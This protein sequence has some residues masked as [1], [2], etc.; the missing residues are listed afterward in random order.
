MTV[1]PE[2]DPIANLDPVAV[3]KALS[4]CKSAKAFSQSGGQHAYSPDG[5]GELGQIAIGILSRGVAAISESC[6]ESILTFS[7]H[8]CLSTEEDIPL[9]E[10]HSHTHSLV[11]TVVKQ[12]Y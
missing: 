2:L 9:I 11:G 8:T 4:H 12:L 1:A 10:L 3:E 7:D 5:I 6:F